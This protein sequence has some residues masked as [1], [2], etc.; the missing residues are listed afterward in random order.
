MKLLT[1]EDMR[2][3]PMRSELEGT[4]P[5]VRVKFFH[6]WST[7]KLWVVAAEAIVDLGDRYAHVPLRDIKEVTFGRLHRQRFFHEVDGTSF[8]VEDIWLYGYGGGT[9]REWG[10][11]SYNEMASLI[12]R[13]LGVERD[14]YFEPRPFS[15]VEEAH[16]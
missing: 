13:G 12:L 8:P 16:Q 9:D 1:V 2:K 10:D 11:S 7:W 5:V 14:M 15:K 6:P 3:I 4:D